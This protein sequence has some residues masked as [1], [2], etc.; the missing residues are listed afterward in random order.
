MAELARAGFHTIAQDRATSIIFGMP[1]AA[2]EAGS[3]QE[4]LALEQIGPRLR[5]LLAA[6]PAAGQGL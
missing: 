6:A 5:E 4:V 3:A 1:R 2:I